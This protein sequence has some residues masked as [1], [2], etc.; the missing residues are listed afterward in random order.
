MTKFLHQPK[1]VRNKKYR[2]YYDERNNRFLEIYC[3][4]LDNH[5]VKNRI[6]TRQLL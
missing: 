4:I 5:R 1:F 2:C 6:K 3:S